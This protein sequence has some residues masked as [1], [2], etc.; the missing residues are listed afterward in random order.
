MPTSDRER[1]KL[2]I[3]ESMLKHLVPIRDL[4]PE[5]RRHLASKAHVVDL[6]PGDHLIDIDEHRWLLY[7]IEG[8][9]DLIDRDRH[10]LKV[11]AGDKRAFH[12]LFADKSHKVRAVAVKRCKVARFDRQLFSTLIEQEIISGEQLETIEVGE[13]EGHIFNAIMQA[14]NQGQLKL[15]SLPEIAVKIKT[16]ASNP[17]A[18]VQDVVRIVEADP[19]MVARLIQVANSPISRGIEPVKSIRDA[20]VRLGLATTRNLVVSLSV[21][22]LFKTRSNVLRARM[23]GLYDHS[24]EVAAIA[25]A[26]ANRSTDMVADELLLAG[27]IHDIGV[28]PILTYID[29]TGLEVE[30]DAQIENIITKLRSVVGSM[31]MKNWDFAPELAAVVECGHDWHRNSGEQLVMCDIIIIAQIYYLLKHHQLD[32]LPQ[33]D[34]VPAFRKLFHDRND[35]QFVVKVLE[36]AHEEIAEVMKIL[37][38]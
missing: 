10:S 23:Q 6:I 11:N 8:T 18:S 30:D 36:D 13:V 25:Y 24:V 37:R 21:K 34:K 20:V 5:G 3:D 7:L 2:P 31:V 1:L 9:I 29:E 17:N 14:F 22:Q 15:P 38:M 32:G 27:L 35:P 28:I 4:Q 16:A 33:I 26:I 19:A 12:A